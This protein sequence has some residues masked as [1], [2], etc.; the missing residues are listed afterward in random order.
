M[1]ISFVSSDFAWAMKTSARKSLAQFT[2]ALF[3]YGGD[4]ELYR[5]SAKQNAAYRSAS[6]SASIKNQVA[7]CKRLDIPTHIICDRLQT[8]WL[9]ILY[10]SINLGYPNIR[11]GPNTDLY[12]TL[13]SHTWYV[14]SVYSVHCTGT[15]VHCACTTTVQPAE[16]RNQ[17]INENI[18]RNTADDCVLRH[19]SSPVINQLD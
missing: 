3:W 9:N 13:F 14:W 16:I 12:S 15:M 8:N 17:K 18:S 6:T 10:R 1:L 5:N 7:P 19:V 4:R 11:W 2:L